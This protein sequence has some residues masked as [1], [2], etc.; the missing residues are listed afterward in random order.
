MGALRIRKNDIV[1][2]RTG[3]S[4]GHQGRVLEVYPEEQR[5]LVEGAAFVWKH[6]RK[7]QEY[8]KGAR[9]KKERPLPVSIVQV[10]CQS[11]NKPTKVTVKHVEGASRVR[12]CR[13]CKQG[14]SP[15][16]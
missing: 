9:I 11:C 15:Q 13:L 5:V 7:S 3:T 16:G 8:P 2:V 10:V 1:K 12:I 4:R 14:V 6:M